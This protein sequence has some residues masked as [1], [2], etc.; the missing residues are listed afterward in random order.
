MTQESEAL[1]RLQEIG[2]RAGEA[3]NRRS[4]RMMLTMVRTKEPRGERVKLIAN[5]KSP[6]GEI[7][8]TADNGDGRVR[9]NAWFDPTDVLAFCMAKAETLGGSIPVVFA[10]R[11]PTHD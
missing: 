8:S 5:M 11:E 4:E 9:V 10:V 6:L 2:L 7:A 3:I 1:A